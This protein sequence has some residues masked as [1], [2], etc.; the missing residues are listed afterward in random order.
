MNINLIFHLHHK[1]IRLWILVIFSVV[2][3]FHVAGQEG[4]AVVSPDAGGKWVPVIM[5]T[6]IY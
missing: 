3:G 6:A 2:T 4:T 5:E 1:Q